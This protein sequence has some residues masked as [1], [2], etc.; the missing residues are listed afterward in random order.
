MSARAWTEIPM[1][2]TVD[3]ASLR[4][5]RGARARELMNVAQ[6]QAAGLEV[7]TM[8]ESARQPDPPTSRAPDT[9]GIEVGGRVFP[10][11]PRLG[12]ETCKP[13]SETSLA[14]QF[15][16]ENTQQLRSVAYWIVRQD[17]QPEG[18]CAQTDGDLAHLCQGRG[19]FDIGVSLPLRG[20]SGK[21]NPN[22]T[23]RT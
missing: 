21:A 20:G 3:R 7:P 6:H 13:V 5:L 23:E 8:A 11:A 22:S 2:R 12:I 1:R 14:Q 4:S 15:V 16:R 19:R 9:S 18:P 10:I 17:G